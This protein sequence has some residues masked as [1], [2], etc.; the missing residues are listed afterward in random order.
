MANG[1]NGKLGSW[2]LLAGVNQAIYVCNQDQATALT[3]SVVNRSAQPAKIRVA[4]S[5]SQVGPALSEYIEFDM[6]LLPKG[7]LERNGLLVG[8]GQYVVVKSDV[9]PVNAVCWGI[10]VGEKIGSITLGANTGTAPTWV[11]PAGSLGTLTTGTNGVSD[12]VSLVATDPY[13]AQ[14]QYTLT[15]GSLPAGMQLGRDGT[16]FNIKTTTGYTSGTTGQTTSFDVTASNG[17]NPVARSFSI[18]KKWNDGST[19]ALAAPSGYWLAQNIGSSYLGSGNYWIKSA[20]MPNAL[21]M[22]VDMSEEGGGYDFY[23]ITGGISA[24]AYSDINSGTALGLDLVMPRS[25]YHWRAM[26]NY[27]SNVVGS[28]DYTYFASVPGIYRTTTTTGGTYVSYPMRS[29]HYSTGGDRTTYAPDWQVKDGGR[30]WLRDTVYTEPNGDYTLGGF[31]GDLSSRAGLPNGYS[32]QDV[33]F[34]DGGSYATGTSYLVST[35]AKP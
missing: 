16:L 6:E 24:S 22:Y 28:T 3:I 35:N 23:R 20:A 11:T 14:L 18:T 26:R 2:N 7:V 8:P 1:T 13:S 9:A 5:D 33:M 12:F 32:L 29:W 34:N 30:W 15:S 10:E 17:T 21:S 19:Q 25:K 31:L 4:I 27:V